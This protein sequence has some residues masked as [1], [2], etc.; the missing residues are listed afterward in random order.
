[1]VKYSKT[2]AY[3]S[4]TNPALTRGQWELRGRVVRGDGEGR[5]LGYPTANLTRYY[6]RW[7]PVS[8]G[9]YAG[10]ASLG[11]RRYAAAACVGVQRK[12]EVYLI[13]YKGRCYGRHLAVILVR[14]LRGLRNYKSDTALKRQIARDVAAVIK[15]LG[16]RKAK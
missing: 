16:H 7:H 5:R 4:R 6:F 9:I 15:I 13:G 14:R 10:W 1:M 2:R 8:L 3:S 12:I 11:R